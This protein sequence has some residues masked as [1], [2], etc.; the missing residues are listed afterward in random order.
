MKLKIGMIVAYKPTATEMGFMKERQSVCNIKEN[1]P[2]IVV[3][4]D[5]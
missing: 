2:A 5:E 1:L 4:I 3:A